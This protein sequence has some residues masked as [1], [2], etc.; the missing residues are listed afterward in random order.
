[1]RSLFTKIR[2]YFQPERHCFDVSSADHADHLSCS[3][4]SQSGN[5]RLIGQE[6]AMDMLIMSKLQNKQERAIPHNCFPT[7]GLIVTAGFTVCII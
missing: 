6:L 5:N 3:S 7:R 4:A 2:G 1:M